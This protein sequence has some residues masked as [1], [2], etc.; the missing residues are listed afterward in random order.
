MLGDKAGVLLSTN[1]CCSASQ[2]TRGDI[3]MDSDRLFIAH[4]S[5]NEDACQDSSV[6]IMELADKVKTSFALET[7]TS[8]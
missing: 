5:D 6:K 1:V 3:C 7:I 2:S 4:V 8:I